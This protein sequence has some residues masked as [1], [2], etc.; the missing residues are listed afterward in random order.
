MWIPDEV[1][2]ANLSGTADNGSMVLL[3]GEDHRSKSSVSPG[4]SEGILRSCNVPIFYPSNIE[5]VIEL[6]L[7][8]VNLS[9]HSGLVT[10]L[11]MV[12]PVCDGGSTVHLNR[13]RPRIVLPSLNYSKKFNRIVMAER[14]VPMQKEL[15]ERKL[16]IAEQY[17]HLNKLMFIF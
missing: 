11:K 6:G 14:A 13:V 1:W 10:A 8:A 16:P 7:H 17:I 15:V 3:C 4:A 5:E 2:L 9:R 12:T